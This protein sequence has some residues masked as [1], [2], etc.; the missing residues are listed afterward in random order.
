MTEYKVIDLKF[1]KSMF[2][3]LKEYLDCKD[4]VEWQLLQLISPYLRCDALKQFG[5]YKCARYQRGFAYKGNMNM[6]NS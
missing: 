2:D 3:S 1:I 4:S 5:N 6:R